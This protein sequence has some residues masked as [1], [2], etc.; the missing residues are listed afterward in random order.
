MNT[1]K[2]LLGDTM[3]LKTVIHLIRLELFF[4]VWV[5]KYLVGVY[6]GSTVNTSPIY[7]PIV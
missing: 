7:L 5:K 2:V 3:R 6:C 1:M 4:I